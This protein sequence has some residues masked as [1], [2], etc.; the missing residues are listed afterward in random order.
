MVV[1]P[2][3]FREYDIRGLV[4]KDLTDETVRL[5]GRG[6]STYLIQ[7]GV[8]TLSI[9]GDVRLSSGRYMD[10]LRQAAVDSGLNVVMLGF[11]PTPLSYY[12]LFKLDIGGSIMVT[13]SHNPADFNG[14][15]LGLGH[16][17]IYG[18]EIKKVLEIIQTG[19]FVNG[20]GSATEYNITTD[21]EAMILDRFSFK[22]KLKVVVDAGNGTAAIFVPGLLRKAGIEVVELFCDVDGSF[23]NHHPDPT[24]EKNLVDL[25]KK[26]AESGADVG[27][28]FDG[29]SDRIGVVDNNGSV[30]WGDYLLLLY[31][32][33]ML[34]QKPGA[35]VIYEVKCSQALEEEISKAGGV[36]IMWKTGHSLLKAKMKETGALIAGEMSGH[37]FFADRYFGYDDAIYAALRLLEILDK[38]SE[39]LSDIVDRLPR[40]VSTPELRLECANDTEKFKIT[41]KAVEYFQKIN[42][43]ITID[44]VRIL[45]GDGWGL[46]RSSNTQPILVLR[47]EARTE[48]RLQEIK[49]MVISKLKEFGSFTE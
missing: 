39:K 31:A 49:S 45:F 11:V 6:Y 34:K 19:S 2:F 35:S 8:T 18:Q 32:L 42:R 33:D 48:A 43:T 21:Y 41:E 25:K 4:G 1:N 20:R 29:D 44:G 24:V 3:I 36:P 47:F 12:S 40:Y 30:I 23:P 26:V 37:M 10:I 22:K 7:K 38:S 5:I 16:T 46:I 14:F 27:V 13:G 17:T 9:G 15:K 28:A